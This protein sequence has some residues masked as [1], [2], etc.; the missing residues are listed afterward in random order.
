MM[1]MFMMVMVM[2][3]MMVTVMMM[4]ILTLMIIIKIINM[5]LPFNQP[6]NVCLFSN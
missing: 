3:F 6:D 4:E 1:M 2:M 5:M